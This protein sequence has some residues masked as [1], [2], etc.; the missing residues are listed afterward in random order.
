VRNSRRSIPEH[1]NIIVEEWRLL[2]CHA[3]WLL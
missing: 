3:A 2:G 1:D